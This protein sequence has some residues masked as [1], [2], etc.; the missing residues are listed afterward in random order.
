MRESAGKCKL[1]NDGTV[2]TMATGNGA[3]FSV[4]D[5]SMIGEEIAL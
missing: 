3:D 2:E 5:N 1:L 4:S